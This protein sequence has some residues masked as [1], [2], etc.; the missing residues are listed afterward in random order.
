MLHRLT[1]TFSI[2]CCR[3][4][5]RGDL[6]KR[7]TTSQPGQK[8]LKKEMERKKG[9]EPS[10][11]SLARTRSTAELLPP[12]IELAEVLNR[13]LAAPSNRLQSIRP[14]MLFCICGR[15]NEYT[16]GAGFSTSNPPR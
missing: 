3:R 4:R 8:D 6:I 2:Q 9:F 15:S 13:Y 10:T 11:S 5:E 1:N 12:D 14:A 7:I 16:T